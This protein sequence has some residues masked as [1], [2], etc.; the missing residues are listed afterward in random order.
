MARP[1][2]P[3][4]RAPSTSTSSKTKSKIHKHPTKRRHPR[5]A[6]PPASSTPLLSQ[7]R[8]PTSPHLPRDPSSTTI[9]GITLG[10]RRALSKSAVRRRR[11]RAG[12]EL[13]GGTLT[14]LADALDVALGDDGDEGDAGAGGDEAGRTKALAQ[15]SDER[16]RRVAAIRE[17][18]KTQPG[19]Q[20]RKEKVA[21]ME[22]ERFKGNVGV[23]MGGGGAEAQSNKWAALRHQIQGAMAQ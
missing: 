10:D 19:V 14:D 5:L 17:S 1:H 23:L 7:A 11:R 12:Q 2:A 8:N 20:R 9:R 4:S 15:S 16:S 3:P 21:N 18:I 22:R 6:Q 13:G